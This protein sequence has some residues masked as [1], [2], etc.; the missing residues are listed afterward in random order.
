VKPQP[1]K[2]MG[3]KKYKKTLKLMNL[4]ALQKYAKQLEGQ[5]SA[6]YKDPDTI[7]GKLASAYNDVIGANQRL[8]ALCA[9]MLKEQGG[10][11]TLSKELLESFKG[12]SVNI[13][14]ELPDGVEKP[15][16]AASYVFSY[17]VIRQPQPP[18]PAPEAQPPAPEPS[19]VPPVPTEQASTPPA[20]EGQ[21]GSIGPS[22]PEGYVP[23]QEITPQAEAESAGQGAPEEESSTQT[24][25]TTEVPMDSPVN[26]NSD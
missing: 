14:W 13:K 20:A 6:V 2:P 25:A 16:D 5:L 4:T 15:E 1:P 24:T 22:G 21:G 7:I 9:S 17:D 8:S 18:E 3:F 11:V 23:P 19:Q 26:D 10:R 12:F